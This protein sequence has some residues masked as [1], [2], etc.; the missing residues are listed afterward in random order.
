M[1][2]K[3]VHIREHIA[4]DVDAYVD[5]QTDPEV[6]RYLSWLPRSRA[7]AEASLWDAIEQQSVEDRKRFFFAIVL[8]DTQEVIGDVG[9]TASI[10]SP[11]N[12]GWFLRKSF[13]G[14]GYA[15]EAVKQ[16]IELAFQ[17]ESIDALSASC[18][19]ANAA[20][21]RIMTKCGFI[22]ENKSEGRLWYRQLAE[23]WRQANGGGIA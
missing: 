10:P 15:T 22:L 9:Y 21:I 2:S 3:Q 4:G 20:S 11:G 5:W 7:D 1:M 23:G 17:S 19:C 12:C 13:Q 16:M 6:A 8:N 18:R 14:R